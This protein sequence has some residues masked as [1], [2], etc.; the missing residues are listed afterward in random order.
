MFSALLR[1]SA[2]RKQLKDELLH[3][4]REME[5]AAKAE[6]MRK[7][8]EAAAAK[9][10]LHMSRMEFLTKSNILHVTFYKSAGKFRMPHVPFVSHLQGRYAI[11][12][13]SLPTAD[14]FCLRRRQLWFYM[15]LPQAGACMSMPVC[16][17]LPPVPSF[18]LCVAR[19]FEY[20]AILGRQSLHFFV[21][22]STYAF[23]RNVMNSVPFRHV[24][25]SLFI[26]LSHFHHQLEGAFELAHS[27]KIL[28]SIQR[29]AGPDA[30]D[31]QEDH[32]RCPLPSRTCKR[33]DAG[34]QTLVGGLELWRGYFQSVHPTSGKNIDVSTVV[35]SRFKQGSFQT[36]TLAVL[37]Q[38][39]AHALD[40]CPDS[41]QFRQLKNFF[42]GVSVRQ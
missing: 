38:N 19:A 2:H 13:L 11:S 25:H 10:E 7:Q 31:V 29:H 35:M 41:L 20:A 26:I 32:Y 9:K 1:P 15:C 14:N 4:R 30:L 23:N 34:I 18:L 36:A 33:L 42:K 16:P 17:S 27:I 24:Y 22:L 8:E 40:L 21:H 5:E 12:L 28:Y 37:K 6:E 39:D 3:T